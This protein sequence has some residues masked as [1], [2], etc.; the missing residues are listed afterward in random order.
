MI[1]TS[2]PGKLML[3]GEHSVVYG[4]PCIACA[5]DR[6]LDVYLKESCSGIVLNCMGKRDTYPSDKFNFLSKVI[7]KFIERY[8]RQDFEISTT[9]L[10]KG[11][12]S[13]SATV[14]AGIK[15]LDTFY[16]SMM[17][18]EEIFDLGFDV[19]KEVQGLSSG[20][21]IAVAVYGGVIFY[22]KGKTR[23][24]END[25]ND[26]DLIA[27]NTGIHSSTVEI[28]NEIKEKKQNNEEIIEGIFKTI[29]EIVKRAEISIKNKNRK[30][31]GVLMKM[32]H[33]LLNAIGLSNIEIENL[34]N[35]I[36]DYTYGAK[37]SGAGRGDYIIAICK[38]GK[39][40]ELIE[41]LRK[42][43]IE[44]FEIKPTEGVKLHEI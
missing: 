6:R 22:E 25:V 30:E 19:V 38:E 9:T 32:N 26:I 21:D 7:E 16:G 1:H 17:S 37:I 33:G 8:G 44:A 13:S 43:K 20:Y 15:A 11:L 5:I 14:V 28:V 3:F 35:E 42:Q 27:I 12:G 23:M 31:L 10:G 34:I 39:K 29:S 40:E 18:K 2:A 4:N 36:E 41:I 24:L